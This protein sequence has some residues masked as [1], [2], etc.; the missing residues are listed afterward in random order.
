[1]ISNLFHDKIENGTVFLKSIFFHFAMKCLVAQGRCKVWK[2][3]GRGTF[4][5]VVGIICPPTPLLGTALQW[6]LTVWIVILKDFSGT[7]NLENPIKH[8]LLVNIG[9]PVNFSADQMLGCVR[10]AG[11]WECDVRSHFCTLFW[12]KGQDF[13]LVHLQ[14]PNQ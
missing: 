12:T 2:S 10:A 6:N 13:C 9:F 1:M 5:N 4:R 14:V 3:G 11:F 7:H 8:F